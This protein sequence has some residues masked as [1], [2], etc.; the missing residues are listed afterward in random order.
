MAFKKQLRVQGASDSLGR[1]SGLQC[2]RFWHA[3]MF[4]SASCCGQGSRSQPLRYTQP[5]C[6]AF[7]SASE[8]L[9][10]AQYAQPGE[11]LGQGGHRQGS[12]WRQQKG[13]NSRNGGSRCA[14][15]LLSQV[16]SL[17]LQIPLTLLIFARLI[18]SSC[19]QQQGPILLCACAPSRSQAGPELLRTSTRWA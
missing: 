19:W 10:P 1:L 12:H 7:C 14:V 16:F 8:S 2:L 6:T 18:C 17:L 15:E 13:I 4:F 9:I 3:F 11:K 5:L